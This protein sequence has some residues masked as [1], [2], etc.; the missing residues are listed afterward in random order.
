MNTSFRR[1]CAALAA[2]VLGAGSAEACTGIRLIAKDGSVIYART[3]EFGIDMHSQVMVLPR[4]FAFTSTTA[5]GKPG[6]NWNAKFAAVGMNG[7]GLEVLVDGVNEAGL[8]AGIFYMPGFA[9]YQAVEPDEES[10]AIAPWELVTWLLTNFSTVDEIRAALPQ[11]KVGAVAFESWKMVP[12]VHYIAHDAAGNSLVI[13]FEDGKLNL[14]D[15]PV[16]TFTNA[17]TFDWHLTNLRNFINL[18]PNN[19]GPR[20]VDGLKLD[21]LG[22]G[23]GM[24]GLPGDFTP[25]SRFVRATALAQASEP[26]ANGPEAVA[27]AFHILDSFDIPRG[28]V[29]AGFGADASLELTDWTSASDTRNRTYYFHTQGNRRVRA[30]E[31]MK[32]DLTAATPVTIPLHDEEPV[33]FLTPATEQAAAPKDNDTH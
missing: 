10:Q 21:Q 9:E 12:P 13:E 17:P 33:Q 25:P 16:G 23:S 20:D 24:R 15:N 30:V 4:G 7:E 18:T 2:I 3:M 29:R 14:Y 8:A 6:L 27:Q 11:I 5:S 31:L 1:L 26:G 22:Q 32:C 19:V 28:T